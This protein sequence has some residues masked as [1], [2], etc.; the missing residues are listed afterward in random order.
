M[1]PGGVS[2]DG[3]TGVP[4]LPLGGTIVRTPVP[5]IP[6][7]C[8]AD[9]LLSWRRR[10]LAYMDNHD[11][12][13]TI[14]G[15][16][17]VPV[18]SCQDEGYL[19]RQYGA[20]LVVEHKRTW[21]FILEAAVG[22]P[23]ENNL[24]SCHSVAE[25]WR[26][27]EDWYLPNHPADCQLLVA[28]L[29]N[30]T[31]SDD[32]DPKLFF[33]RVAQLETKLRA[34]GIAKSDQEVVQILV[35]QLPARY[36]V[37]KRTSLSKRD[38]TRAEL[39]DV[40]R[41]R[42]ATLKA[43]EMRERGSAALTPAVSVNPHALVVGRG[44]GHGGNGGSGGG[45]GQRRNGNN[46]DGRGQHWSSGGGVVQQQQPQLQVQQYR[47]PQ[48]PQRHMQQPNQ[49][50][51]R[52]VQQS[53]PQPQQQMRQQ[54]PYQQQSQMQPYRQSQQQP[55]QQRQLQ[56]PA[57]NGVG[58]I[59][60]CGSNAVYHQPESLP[61]PGAP[62]GTVHRCGRC[63]R[64]DH[65]AID[66]AAPRRFEGTCGACGQYGH[67][68]RNCAKSNRHP[69]LNVVTSAGALGPEYAYTT[70]DTSAVQFRDIP[71]A[72]GVYYSD[73]MLTSTGGK[74]NGGTGAGGGGSGGDNGG[75]GG[76][77]IVQQQVVTPGEPY[78]GFV[79]IFHGSGGVEGENGGG[80]GGSD[81]A[82]AGPEALGNGE[83]TFG[84]GLFAMHL[85]CSVTPSPPV[86]EPSDLFPH[87]PGSTVFLG[88]T[89]AVVHVVASGEKVYNRRPPLP[90]ERL[91][92]LGDGKHIPVEFFGDLDVIF[93]C[94]EDVRV[95]LQNVGV[96][97]GL[98]LDI[99]SL[100]KIQDRHEI[101]LNRHGASILGGR[102][103]MTKFPHGNYIQGTRVDP[104]P[105]RDSPPQPPAMVAAM[106]RSGTQSSVDY[107]ALHWSLSHANSKTLYETA[108]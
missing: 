57:L 103:R 102:V 81:A 88:D 84:G 42:Y 36:D 89:G 9:T 67:M 28:E 47:Q 11:L 92:M 34:V 97:P 98:A 39:Q 60:D 23:F 35:R 6:P 93:H 7:N 33:S 29:D 25:A 59:Y 10:F 74:G 14:F 17:E 21:S 107:D 91:L 37:E 78:F 31:M 20:Q 19:T 72:D 54:Q 32:E 41:G 15:S 75:G 80:S 95:T 64:N 66:C 87:R 70:A 43:S 46:C 4:G 5:R 58:G 108:K 62:M 82:G 90:E 8:T 1:W 45:G 49:Q 24:Y 83:G 65:H 73:T 38:L 55:Q 22:A 68:W 48:Q 13:H 101:K 44:F 96:V 52:Q 40:V 50:P 86:R 100:N 106:L 26:M 85:V 77:A 30:I 79:D 53:Y 18:V 56:Q 12:Q 71:A 104:L 61:P 99:L 69:H 16:A 2:H 3:G 63:G 27:M 94:P 76:G 105:Q 51:Q